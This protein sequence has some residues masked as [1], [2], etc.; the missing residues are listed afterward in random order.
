MSLIQGMSG[1]EICELFFGAEGQSLNGDIGDKTEKMRLE[2]RLVRNLRQIK[3]SVS[4]RKAMNR[5]KKCR[6]TSL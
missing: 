4:M 2:H 1:D 3:R 5:W 6:T